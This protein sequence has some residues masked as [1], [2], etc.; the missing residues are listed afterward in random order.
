MQNFNPHSHEGS[1]FQ[2]GTRLVH[3]L[4]IS[5]HTPTKGV[6]STIW[7]SRSFFR[8]S[9]HTPTKGVTNVYPGS[10][11]Y[12][13][14]S[15]HTPTKGVTML[16]PDYLWYV[17]ISIHTPTKGVTATI[18]MITQSTTT[19]FNPHSHEGSDKNDEYIRHRRLSDFNPHSHE[20]SDDRWQCKS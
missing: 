14:I 2:N 16:T 5:I 8:I 7:T 3:R 19:N 6:T 10:R 18:C 11:K 12:S 9:I 15:I 17:P 4:K 1:D 20:G 13:Y